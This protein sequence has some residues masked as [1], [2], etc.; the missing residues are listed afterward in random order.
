MVNVQHGV[1]EEEGKVKE[2][3]RGEENAMGED[4]ARGPTP[5]AVHSVDRGGNQRLMGRASR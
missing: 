2:G 4:L 3:I 1:R 5:S